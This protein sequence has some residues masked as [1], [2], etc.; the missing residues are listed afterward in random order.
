MNMKFLYEIEVFNGNN[1]LIT[2]FDIHIERVSDS[3]S[4]IIDS[5]A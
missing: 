4:T 5:T 2:A 1:S 3:E